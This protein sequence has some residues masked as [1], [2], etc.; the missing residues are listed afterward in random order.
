MWN[1]L[2]RITVGL[3]PDKLALLGS[4]RDLVVRI[5]CRFLDHEYLS[6]VP[7]IFETVVYCGRCARVF[8]HF[9]CPR[10]RKWWADQPPGKM[11]FTPKKVEWQTSSNTPTH[12]IKAKRGK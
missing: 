6:S 5:K 7:R 10:A 8:A 9:D 4:Y 3:V 1:G 12:P 2:R 11:E